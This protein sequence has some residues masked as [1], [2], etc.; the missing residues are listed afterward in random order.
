[1]K[2]PAFIEIWNGIKKKKFYLF[3]DERLC[4]T[5]DGFI[6]C[7][8]CCKNHKGIDVC[9][10]KN[11]IKISTN[12][13]DELICLAGSLRASLFTERSLFFSYMG[14][15]FFIEVP[16]NFCDVEDVFNC[17]GVW[18][19]ELE[20]S[21]CYAR[22]DTT[23]FIMGA[24]GT[25]KELMAQ[26]IHYNSKRRHGPFIVQSCSGLDL[27]TAEQELFGSLKG[28]FTGAELNCDGVFNIAEGGTLVLDDIGS[29]PLQVQPLLLR[30]LELNEVKKLGSDKVKKHN[31]RVLVTSNSSANELLYNSRLRKDLYYRLE[32]NSVY[33]PSLKGAS[34]KIKKLAEFFAGPEYRIENDAMFFLLE[35]NWPGN[36]RELQNVIKRAILFS[37]IQNIKD[38]LIKKEHIVLRNDFDSTLI[39]P[40]KD[41][42]I[43]CGY[44]NEERE[45]IRKTLFRNNWDI[46]AS[47][48][49]L[50]ICRVTLLAKIKEYGL[51]QKN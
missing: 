18:G 30:A 23:V 46:S 5:D 3:K 45:F 11:G 36:V 15:R 32:A 42:S 2:T 12:S 9:L 37:R 17:V 10:S 43:V 24:T 47:A 51:I 13:S 29:L 8:P 4:Y 14:A 41:T 28:A 34:I 48:N 19:E 31:T 1:M 35:H 26:N 44:Q 6:S 39:E 21:M 22:N 25:G 40:V 7:K 27:K 49:D 33:L 16:S 50:N 38:K 20:S